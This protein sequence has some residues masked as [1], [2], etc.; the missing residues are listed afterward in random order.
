MRKAKTDRNHAAIVDAIELAGGLVAQ[1][2]AV[3]RLVPG[4]PDLMVAFRGKW[5]AVEV[6]REG[7]R[8]RLTPA[9]W[10]FHKVFGRHAPILV[11]DSPQDAIRQLTGNLR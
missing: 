4:F 11:V 9:E 5:V 8:D 1:T 6:K 3:G 2:Y 7:H 10:N